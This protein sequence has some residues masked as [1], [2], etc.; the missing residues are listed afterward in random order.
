MKPQLAHNVKVAGNSFV[1]VWTAWQTNYLVE[2]FV[3]QDGAE[4]MFMT[5]A[6]T[7][8]TVFVGQNVSLTPNSHLDFSRI[9]EVTI[10]ATYHHSVIAL[11]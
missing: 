5:A 11:G 7:K 1:L 2:N 9:P 3:I 10:L 8:F 4:M 6:S